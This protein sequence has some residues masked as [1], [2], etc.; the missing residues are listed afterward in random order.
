LAKLGSQNIENK[1]EDC[2]IY[3]SV[4]TADR[5]LFL[6]NCSMHQAELKHPHSRLC[7]GVAQVLA[8][9]NNLPG[10]FPGLS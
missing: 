9:D 1:A 3:D 5:S 4:I 7:L 10:N 8:N 2:Q 6:L